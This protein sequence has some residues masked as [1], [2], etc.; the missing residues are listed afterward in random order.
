MATAT[1]P[2]T[3]VNERLH[4]SDDGTVWRVWDR[5]DVR[6]T[7]ADI[8]GHIRDRDLW[9]VVPDWLLPSLMAIEA[10]WDRRQTR[11]AA[12]DWDIFNVG[13]F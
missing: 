6:E 2:Q 1:T 7:D 5:P 9:K 4:L 3:R 10:M 13:V 11:G 8:L 12:M